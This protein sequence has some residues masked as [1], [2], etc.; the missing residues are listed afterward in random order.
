MRIFPRDQNK[1][2]LARRANVRRG[3]ILPWLVLSL[4]IVIGIVA[5]T[6][7]G[8][9]MLDERRHVQAAADAAA[10]A[11]GADL[12]EHYWTN[13]GLDP[14][15]TAKTA[16]QNAAAAN[17]IP[18]SAVTVNIPPLA[19]T[20][21]GQ[22]GYVEVSIQSELEATFGRIFTSQDLGA[23]GR[24]VARGE[25]MKIGLIL[26]RPSGADAFLNKALA[27]TVV[28]NPLVVNSSDAA[29]YDEPTFGVTIAKRYDIT[30]GYVNTGG[31][32][33]LG[34]IRTGVRPAP[35]PLAFLPVPSTGGATIQSAAPLT[36]NSLLPTVLQP[37]IYQGGI[38]ITGLSPVVMQ[39]GVYIMQGGGFQVDG[40]A[41]VLGTGVMIYNT[42]STTYASGS[43]SVT[44]T[45]KVALAAPLSGTYQGISFF[46][47][48]TLNA[49]IT[50]SGVGLAVIT[51]VVYAPQAPVSLTGLAVAGLD[52]LGGA[53]VVD[54]MTV[55]GIGAINIDLKLNPPRVPDVCLVE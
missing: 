35:D 55:Q 17:G 10:L 48:R 39:P 25:P 13:Q 18:A 54:S 46:Q 42:T 23:A 51:G 4:G 16:A 1:P 34:P 43:I 36:I 9:R 7:D 31:A 38:H 41:T 8:G 30:G 28:N 32:L 29:G 53:Y 52:V 24:S 12:Y 11:A 3:H 21:A 44:A 26:L 5:I 47:D 33:M 40:A 19:G 37:G 14:Q 49:P 45:G 50:M 15:H 27:F 6:L 22:A 2:L 20:F